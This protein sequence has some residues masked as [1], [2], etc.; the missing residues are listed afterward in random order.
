[1]TRSLVAVELPL[2]EGRGGRAQSLAYSDRRRLETAQYILEKHERVM[3]ATPRLRQIYLH[4]CGVAYARLGNYAD[5][6]KFFWRAWLAKRST[7]KEL[8]RLAVAFVPAIAV[9]VWPPSE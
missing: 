6:R 2:E 3:T 5:A 7:V 1:M 9:R 4:I 8:A